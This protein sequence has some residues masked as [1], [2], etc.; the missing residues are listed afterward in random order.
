MYRLELFLVLIH[1]LN[2]FSKPIFPEMMRRIE[3]EVDSVFYGYVNGD[4]ILS[5][6]VVTILRELSTNLRSSF[7]LKSGVGGGEYLWSL[8]I[9]CRP[10][11]RSGT[12][13]SHLHLTQCI[14]IIIQ[15]LV[16]RRIYAKSTLCCIFVIPL[17]FRIISFTLIAWCQGKIRTMNRSYWV[18]SISTTGSWGPLRWI[19][20]IW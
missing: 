17:S 10:C 19:T 14:S 15:P 5:P 13:Q 6:N 3:K 18:G 11:K 2:E 16:H 8:G 9:A 1:R 4:I 7:I 12:C 20:V